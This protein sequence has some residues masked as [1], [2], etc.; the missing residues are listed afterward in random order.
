VDRK[1]GERKTLFV[2]HAAVSLCGSIQPGVLARALSADFLDAGLAARLLMAMPPKVAKYSGAL[3]GELIDQ[4]LRSVDNQGHPVTPRVSRSPGCPHAR[5]KEDLFRAAEAVAAC[6]ASAL[7][8]LPHPA[9]RVGPAGTAAAVVGGTEHDPE[10]SGPDSRPGPAPR[11]Q[12]GAA[13]PR[14]RP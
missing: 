2:P 14:P 8:P 6:P 4:Q 9:G 7:A 11:P 1:T 13:L 12:V 3:K 5:P 10:A